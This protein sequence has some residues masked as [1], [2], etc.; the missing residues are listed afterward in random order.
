[1]KKTLLEKF[2]AGGQFFNIRGDLR[3]ICVD[4]QVFC[5]VFGIQAHVL[6]FVPGS[7]GNVG[8]NYGISLQH[9]IVIGAGQLESEI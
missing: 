6:H 1:M 8:I 7:A 3:H 5:C 9:F 4:M 2:G